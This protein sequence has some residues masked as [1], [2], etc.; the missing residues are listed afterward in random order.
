[1]NLNQ[2]VPVGP[3]RS[4]RRGF[5]ATAVLGATASLVAACSAPNSPAPAARAPEPTSSPSKAAPTAVPAAGG[6]KRQ[7]VRSAFQPYGGA[8]SPAAANMDRNRILEQYVNVTATYIPLLSGPAVNEA[9]LAGSADFG[10]I[11]PFPTMSMLGRKAEIEL[12]LQAEGAVDHAIMVRTNA[13]VDDL[14]TFLAKKPSIGVVVGSSAHQFLDSVTQAH[15]G[16]TAADAGIKLVNLDLPTQATLPDGVD[17][18]LP[19]APTTLQ[20]ESR[21]SGVRYLSSNGMTGEAYPGGAGKT[22]P[23]FEKAQG[24]PEGYFLHRTFWVVRRAFAKEHPDLVQA[25]ARAY[26][27]SVFDLAAN[28][29]KAFTLSEVYW[30]LP[31]DLAVKIIAGDLIVG[32][33]NWVWP[34]YSDL[35]ALIDGS[36][37][38]AQQKA[39]PQPL[40]WADIVG[41]T[42]VSRDLV[43]QAYTQGAQNSGP[44]YPKD[45]EFTAMAKDARGA[46]MWQVSELA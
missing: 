18:V 34:T 17:A 10:E 13:K 43:K 30:R 5:L 23:G 6:A 8:T 31:E 3:G 32:Q 38:V 21:K 1:M 19:W 45:T 39:I 28:H 42:R 46:P 11:G 14:Q 24:Y 44:S 26:Q 22:L 12:L 7:E 2:P 35:K 36:T 20:M 37:F 33:R 15:V 27:H 4:T 40:T 29:N 16:K 41:A 25:F 9:L